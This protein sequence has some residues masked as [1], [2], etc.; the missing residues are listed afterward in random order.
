MSGHVEGRVIWSRR[1]FLREGSVA[2]GAVTAGTLCGPSLVT[3]LAPSAAL[4]SPAGA[5]MATLLASGPVLSFHLDQPYI[6]PTGAAL[7]YR[8]PIGA[9]GG[10]PVAELTDAELSRYYGFI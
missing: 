6:D 2:A 5:P 3:L 1:R 8:P 10:A 7:A 9:R 4:A